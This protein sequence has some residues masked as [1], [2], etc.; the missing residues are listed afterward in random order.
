MSPSG[1][2][3]E[4]SDEAL[5]E[6]INA[7]DSDA[8]ET[9]YRR[10]RDW[11]VALAYRFTGRQDDALDVAQD[12]FM[13][14]L[15]K[16]PGF[17]LT[18]R[19]TTFLYPVVRH[20]SIATRRKSSRFASDDDPIAH[21]PAESESPNRDPRAELA[22]VMSALPPGQLEVVLM[23]FVDAMTISE[24]A[25]ALTLP[26]GTVKSRLHHALNTLREDPRT[27]RHFEA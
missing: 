2:I 17:K 5:V 10:Y 14:L 13:Y 24:I 22:F 4:I 25:L 3:N 11:V 8:F 12:T 21:I 16:F 19:M 15:R 9:L 7:G 18:A 1:N 6:A 23:R 20:L 26:E 27:R